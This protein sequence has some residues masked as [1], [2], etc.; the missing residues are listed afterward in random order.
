MPLLLALLIYPGRA[1]DS[2]SL[3]EAA[4]TTLLLLA[5]HKAL[6]LTQMTKIQGNLV[7]EG[8]GSCN[9]HFLSYL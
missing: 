1:K 4:L 2:S 8:L 5:D 3:H 6:L 7:A 9:C